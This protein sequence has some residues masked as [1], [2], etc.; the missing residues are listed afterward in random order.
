MWITADPADAPTAQRP[1]ALARF[2]ASLFEPCSWLEPSALAARELLPQT[3]CGRKMRWRIGVESGSGLVI[4]DGIG[5]I[6]FFG[7]D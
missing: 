6:I 1:V 5:G 2:V 4:Q 7:L 3:L